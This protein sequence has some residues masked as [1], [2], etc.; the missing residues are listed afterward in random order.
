MGAD[1]SQRKIYENGK[2]I[3]EQAA[4][5]CK[6]KQ[7]FAFS[8]RRTD[9]TWE[10]WFHCMHFSKLRIVHLKSVHFFES[11]VYLYKSKTEKED[12]MK[13]KKTIPRILV[14]TPWTGERQRVGQASCQRGNET[15]RGLWG[16]AAVPYGS[17]ASAASAHC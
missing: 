5:F 16:G 12:K 4:V 7:T 9:A 11:K 15:Q 10:K 2:G 17:P 14:R 13:I 8:Y 1:A 6:V 3:L